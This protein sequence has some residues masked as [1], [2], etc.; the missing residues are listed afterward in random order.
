MGTRVCLAVDTITY[1]E[2]GGHLWAHL[3]WALGL[4]RAGCDVLW[5]EQAPAGVSDDRLLELART[6]SGHLEPYGFESSLVVVRS[7]GTD[8][9]GMPGL[10][11]A[12][13]CDLLLNFGYSR[14]ASIVGRFRRTALVDIDP[15]LLQVW[16]VDG[17][18]RVADH[19]VLFTTGP[20]VG[21]PGSRVPD[22]GHSWLPTVPCVDVDAWPVIDA[23]PDRPFTTISHWYGDEWIKS[24]DGDYLNDKRSGFLPFVEVAS[25]SP[26]PLELALYL[27]PDEDA[28]RQLLRSHGWRLTQSPTVA[29]TPA[30]YQ[31]YIQRSRGEFSCVKPSCVHLQNGWVSDRTLCYLASG[32][33]AV[34]Q[35]TGPD[36]PLPNGEGVFRFQTPIEAVHALEVIASDYERHSEAARAVAEER[37][38][39][40]DVAA[41]VVERSLT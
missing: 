27:T 14:S 23:G 32:K 39:A 6:L 7:D 12:T 4:R 8:L 11:A 36:C 26:V 16:M 24:S 35:D 31:R 3:N 19:D 29:G 22:A 25:K 5:L 40:R 17:T 1:P 37:F 18:I 34:L 38:S 9:P 2:G 21:R 30:Q 13:E 10:D 20:N 41:S 28:D 33:P 15:G